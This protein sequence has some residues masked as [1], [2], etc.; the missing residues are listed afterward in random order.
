MFVI[1]NLQVRKVKKIPPTPTPN[2][3]ANGYKMNEM[4]PSIKHFFPAF[5]LQ[6]ELS[7]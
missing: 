4:W 3:H 5:I 7:T 1:L 2:H 6:L